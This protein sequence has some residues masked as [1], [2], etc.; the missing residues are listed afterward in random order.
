MCQESVEKVYKLILLV[1]L[2]DCRGW[3]EDVKFI[4]PE[5]SLS[6]GRSAAYLARCLPSEQR[7]L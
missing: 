2:V 5:S 6:P 1:C 3:E 4:P 7:F